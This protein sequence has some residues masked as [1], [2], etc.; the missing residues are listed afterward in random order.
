[1][2]WKVFQSALLAFA[3][4]DVSAYLSSRPSESFNP[5]SLLSQGAMDRFGREITIYAVSIRAPCFRKERLRLT[6]PESVKVRFQSALL[7]F[8]RSDPCS[9]RHC[10][11]RHCFNP[12]SLLSQGAIRMRAGIVPPFPLFQSAPL[13][14]AR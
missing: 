3:R 9:Q 14:F 8:A 7:A 12:R 2:L 10:L 6:A 11:P 4:S 5:R 13:A 1:M